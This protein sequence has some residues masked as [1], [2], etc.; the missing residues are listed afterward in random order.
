MNDWRF[1]V[2]ALSLGLVVT[3]CSAATSPEEA[4]TS[5]DSELSSHSDPNLT[6]AQR[7]WLRR[8]RPATAR[9]HDIQN[10]L[11]DGY[12]NF[13]DN[14]CVSSIVD[15]SY[16]GPAG[17]MG[18]HYMNPAL[19]DGPPDPM[20]PQFLLYEPTADGLRLAGVE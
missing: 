4:T 18:V 5:V 9:Y 17:R 7:D 3:A 6:A 12:V 19:L 11:N 8:L 16:T 1:G 2:C 15:P 20:K 13:D 14:Y 10:A